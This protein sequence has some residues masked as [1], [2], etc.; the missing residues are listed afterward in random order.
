MNQGNPP[1]AFGKDNGIWQDGALLV[2][3][4]SQSQ[5]MAVFLAFQT[6]SWQTDGQGNPAAGAAAQS[7]DSPHSAAGKGPSSPGILR[8]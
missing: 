5:W 3:L 4:P 2:Y 7:Q 6:E 1:G 8:S